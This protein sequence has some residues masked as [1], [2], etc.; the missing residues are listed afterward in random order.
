MN[1][2][3]N[4]SN[5]AK[6]FFGA[7]LCLFSLSLLHG[8]QN[9]KLVFPTPAGFTTSSGQS[10]IPTADGGFLLTGEVDGSDNWAVFGIRIQP[11]LIKLNA[12]SQVEWDQTYLPPPSNRGCFIFPV[13]RTIEMPDG[14]FIQGLHN[15][16]SIVDEVMKINA[17]GSVAWIKNLPNYSR[18]SPVIGKLANNNI[19]VVRYEYAINATKIYHLDTDGNTVFEA[20][21]QINQNYSDGVILLSND[22]LLFYVYN[23]STQKYKLYRTTSQGSLIW[24]SGNL[25]GDWT[26]LS[27][28][29]GGGFARLVSTSNSFKYDYYGADNAFIQSSID[30]AKGGNAVNHVARSADGSLLLS[31]TTPT[32][33]GFMS[34]MAADGTA[35]WAV[36][37][38]EDG[39]PHLKNLNG[40]PTTDGWGAGVG[41]VVGGLF[42]FLRVFE[43]TGIFINHLSGRVAKDN[44]MDCSVQGAEPGI[45]AAWVKATRGNETFTASTTSN[46]SYSFALP[47]GSY[48]ISAG[49]N[50]LFFEL[51]PTVN[52]SVDFPPQT[53]GSATLD[54][55]MQTDDLI[56]QL[57][58]KFILDQNGNCIADPGEPAVANWNI[59]ISE[60]SDFRNL[61]TNNQGEYSIFVPESVLSVEA[62]P[63]NS[64]YGICGNAERQVVFSGSS[65]LT[66]TEDFVVFPTVD[67]ALMRIAIENSSVRPCTTYTN[68]ISYRNDG[69]KL[70]EDV[71][72]TVSLDPA[73]H[74]VSS[75]P[76]AVV[77]G[78][79]LTFD[80]GDVP[81]QPGGDWD[82]VKF[83]FTADCGLQI[84]QQVCLSATVTPAELCSTP[85]LWQGALID[86]DGDCE[87]DSVAFTI[88]NI[89]N[90]NQVMSLDFIIA[91]DQIVL[92]Q[93]N[94][95]LPPGGEKTEKVKPLSANSTIGIVADQ[96]MGAPGDTTVSFSL[97]NCLGMG[98]GNP[99]GN[100]GNGGIFSAN[101]CWEVVNSFDP[102]D[103]NAFPLGYGPDRLVRPGTPIDY[104]IRFQNTGNDTAFLVILRD[105]LD[106]KFDFGQIEVLGGS[107]PYSFS[108]INDSILHLRFDNISLPD[109]AA[110]PEGSQG[111]LSF[112]IYPRAGLPLETVVSNR[113]AIYFDH[114]PPIITNTVSRK[115]GEYFVVKTD[116][117][118]DKSLKITCLP[119]PFT[120]E[121]RFFL[122]EDASEGD[123]QLT[124]YD[125]SGRLLQRLH[126]NGNQCLVQRGTLPSGVLFWRVECEGKM[127][128]SGRIVAGE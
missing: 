17:D 118:G 104:T 73:M 31:G 107:H 112:R 12:G 122:P 120:A 96:E 109:S 13:G 11:R 125:A 2:Q 68:S 114:N 34:K 29:P 74:Y 20:T 124:L 44:N 90:G 86:V 37:S 33:R 63:Y 50:E 101:K 18:E 30:Y 6:S 85:P 98:G 48:T 64:H 10:L 55:P 3:I 87:Q 116:D 69:T 84:G 128:A 51:C 117:P 60:G 113:A 76:P 53:N 83:T 92:R 93:G 88:K 28:M 14:G 81:P 19:V 100:G 102:N 75:N 35:I 99:G 78:N 57:K 41:D 67:C 61:K 77:N 97:T 66:I 5:L 89:G 9:Q 7:I 62:F 126:F 38:P 91:E 119:N 115:Y 40:I 95:N 54:L 123:Y 121:T 71:T 65:P 70:A 22:D 94:F 105:T 46:G 56:H 42:G 110:N 45:H 82:Y 47:A 79:L 36:E 4:L 32:Q 25:T 108:Q 43:N 127:Q 103:K 26:R 27:P 15:D 52:T 72:L 16:S 106:S 21:F 80:L 8:Q 111:Y 39:Q 1:K 58:G 24:E 59:Q 49:T 23:F